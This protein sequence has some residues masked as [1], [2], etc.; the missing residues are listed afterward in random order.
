[1]CDNIAST[2]VNVVS[3]HLKGVVCQKPHIQNRLSLRFGALDSFEGG[4]SQCLLVPVAG[5]VSLYG[6]SG[7]VFRVGRSG[8]NVLVGKLPSNSA[9]RFECSR[10]LV[11]LRF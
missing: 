4:A 8:F 1:M 11:S 2:V 7:F 5:L 3:F 10:D 6:L 9:A